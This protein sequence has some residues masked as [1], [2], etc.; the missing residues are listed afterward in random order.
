MD[1]ISTLDVGKKYSLNRLINYGVWLFTIVILLQNFGLN[2]SVILAGSAA[3]LVGIGLG[4]QNV[5]SDFFSR[6]G[7]SSGLFCKSRRY[8]QFG[9]NGMSG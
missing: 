1:R 2:L 3:L 7:Y 4:L 6:S 5:F 8:Y 9:R